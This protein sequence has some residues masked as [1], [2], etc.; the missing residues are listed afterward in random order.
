VLIQELL[1][2]AGMVVPGVVQDHHHALVP[3][4]VAKQLAQECP[5]RL[6]VEGVREGVDELPGAQVDGT[7]AGY[8]LPR[9]SMQH[10]RVLDLNRN[11]HPQARAMTL[12]MAFIKVPK[13][14]VI[15]FR[16]A[17]RFF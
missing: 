17:F 15:P 11:P 3:R 8:G 2:E 12:E 9:R 4:S 16:Q 1:E 7:K 6:G 10:H 5:E 13:L 14:N